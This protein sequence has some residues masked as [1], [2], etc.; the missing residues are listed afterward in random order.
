MV[1]TP[2]NFGNYVKQAPKHQNLMKLGVAVENEI[3]R[4][5]SMHV[6]NFRNLG[7][8]KLF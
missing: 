3:T 7:E 8:K 1:K 5:V 6:K 2:V 4:H